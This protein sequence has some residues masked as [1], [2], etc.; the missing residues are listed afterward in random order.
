LDSIPLNADNTII[1]A[2]VITVIPMTEILVI[3]LIKFFFRLT[4]RYLLA[5]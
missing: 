4:L 3:K 1:N 2:A 5:M